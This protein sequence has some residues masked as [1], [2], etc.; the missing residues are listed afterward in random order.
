MI[1]GMIRANLFDGNDEGADLSVR[2]LNQRLGADQVQHSLYQTEHI[3]SIPL[4][5]R[6]KAEGYVQRMLKAW[7]SWH[8][9]ARLFL[10]ASGGLL[11]TILRPVLPCNAA[12]TR[13]SHTCHRMYMLN[14]HLATHQE[15]YLEDDARNR[16]AQVL[17]THRLN[18]DATLRSLC[19]LFERSR[20]SNLPTEQ[21]RVFLRR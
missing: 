15:G 13:V 7:D 21:H 6:S 14:H 11:D 12:A 10:L 9:C 4:L 18:A 19:D 17:L 1:A 2:L 8:R 20:E 5:C 16:R 3:S